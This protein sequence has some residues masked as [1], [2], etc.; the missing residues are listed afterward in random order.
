MGPELSIRLCRATP[1]QIDALLDIDD[2]A[3]LLFSEA[4]FRF[5]GENLAAFVAAER[6]RWL[7]AA[8]Q[9]RVELALDSA[10]HTLGFVVLAFADGAPYL[11]QLSVRR[12]WM[13]RGVGRTLLARAVA[14]SEALGDLWLT[15]YAHVPWNGPMYRRWGFE[16][17]D[18]AR[19]GPQ[20]RALLAEQ[21]GALP[22]PAQRIAMLRVRGSAATSP[23]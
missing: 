11:D 13:R 9:G 18:E 3:A 17:V 15:T 19:C 5:D 16:P 12:R 14:W 2:D 22:D 10:G 23:A 21:R 4:G 7:A 20:I 1:Q 6:A 8:E